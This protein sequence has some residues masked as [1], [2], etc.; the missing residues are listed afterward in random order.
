MEK[1]TTTKKIKDMG[2]GVF[3]NQNLTKGQ[4]VVRGRGL[5][6]EKERTVHSFQVDRDK[7]MQLDKASRSINHSC[8][9]NTGVRNNDTRGYDFVALRDI[10]AGEEIT[11][12]YETAEYEIAWMRKCRCGSK[13]CRGEVRGF[14]YLD[15]KTKDRYGEFIADY[16]KSS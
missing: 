8:D 12:N 5:Y 3:A 13:K 16:L 6:Q 7:H 15:D 9:P 11:W 2:V 4:V 14:K 10:E 1:L